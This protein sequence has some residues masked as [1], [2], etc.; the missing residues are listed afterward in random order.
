LSPRRETGRGLFRWDDAE[1]LA[2]IRGPGG[3]LWHRGAA[4]RDPVAPAQK[5]LKLSAKDRGRS[6]KIAIERE[7]ILVDR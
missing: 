1:V 3:D 7:E 5:I 6:Q 2:R 4:H